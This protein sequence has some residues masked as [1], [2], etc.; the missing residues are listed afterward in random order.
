MNHSSGGK[1]LLYH[2]ASVERISA[3]IFYASSLRAPAGASLSDRPVATARLQTGHLED[4]LF[5]RRLINV[6]AFE[7][8]PLLSAG[9]SQR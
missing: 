3:G 1:Y 7:T 6:V 8:S 9:D 4:I 5:G 2:H